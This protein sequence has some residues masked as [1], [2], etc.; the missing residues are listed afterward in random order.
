MKDKKKLQLTIIAIVITI[1]IIFIYKGA[2]A[3]KLYDKYLNTGIKYLMDGQ[4]EE[5][6]LAFDKAIKI[7]SKATEVRVYQV[8]AYIGNEE[9]DKAVE[10]LEETQNIDITNEELLKEILDILNE[11]DTDI[12]YEFLDRFI[13]E[14]GKD[15][16]SKEVNDI[17]NS[18][19]EAPSAPVA[20]PTPGPYIEAISVK[21]KLDKLKVGHSYYYTLDGSEPNKDSEKYRGDIEITESTTIKLIGYN[22][23]DESTEVIILENIIDKDIIYET[24]NSIEKAENLISNTNVGNKVGEI[25]R[26]LQ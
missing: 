25:S 16:L 5:A 8:K 15:N 7:E 24:K 6:I 4:Y 3:P 10:V 14:V 9:L 17:L 2:I 1:S 19:N 21:L 23:N 18:A 20:D 13:E 11:I 22:R 12:S 26:E